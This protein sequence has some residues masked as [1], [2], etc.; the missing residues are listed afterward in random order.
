MNT[1]I[2]KPEY[3]Y[4]RRHIRD[5]L[6]WN[7]KRTNS[8]LILDNHADFNNIIDPP[9]IADPPDNLRLHNNQEDFMD[10]DPQNG[11]SKRKHKSKKSRRSQKKRKVLR[12]T[13]K[14]RIIKRK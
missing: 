5:I 12:K 13:K 2:V 1:I 9:D 14:H 8:S 7:L 10:I 11:G 3:T 6:E 4:Y